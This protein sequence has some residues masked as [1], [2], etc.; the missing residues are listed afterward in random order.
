MVQDAWGRHIDYIRLSLT[1]ACNFCCPYCRPTEITTD[2]QLELLSVYEWMVI[3]EAFHLLGVRAI[4]LTGGEPLLYPYVHELLERIYKTG[5]FEDISMTTNG[6]LLSHEAHRLRKLGLNRVNISLDSLDADIF[7]SCVGKQNQLPN[8]LSGI[9]AALSAEFDAVKINT[10]LTRQ[11]T[12]DEILD[13]LSYVKKWKIV[14]RAIEYMPFQHKKF[15]GP[16]FM[17]WKSQIERLVG[18]P[19]VE[20]ETVKGFGPASYY[21][22]PNEI[23]IGFIFAMSHRYCKHCNRVRLTSDGYLR[24]CLLHDDES[25]LINLVRNG[26]KSNELADHIKNVLQLKKEAH[27]GKSIVQPAR[28]MWKIGG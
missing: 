24:L 3:I 8:V 11:W 7:A 26:M 6:S 22:L 13:V 10:V 27:D 19:L 21:Q 9:E 5:W 14:W 2:T 25:N 4:R 28:P 12:D 15:D 1:E 16:T 23:I 17:E 18:A 20:V